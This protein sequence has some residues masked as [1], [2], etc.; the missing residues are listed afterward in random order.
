[1]DWQAS[2]AALADKLGA[3]GELRDPAWREAFEH[4]PRHV[5]VSGFDLREAYADEALVTQRRRAK[6]P[7]GDGID[8]PT[9]SASAPGVVAVMLDRLAVA[10]GMRVLEIGTGTGYNAALL[11][12]RLG[13]SNVYSIDLDPGLM[14]EAGTA[15]DAAG[16][17]PPLRAG[18]GYAG[19]PNAAP[20][21]RIIATC[22][23]N[24]IPPAWIDQLAQ[25]GRIVA[26][27]LGDECALMVLDKT[28][29]DEVTGRFDPYQVS[30][31]PLRDKI[32]N[33][34]AP[35]R[36]L[37]QV[38]STIGQYGTTDL[39]PSILDNTDRDLIMLL[40]LHLPGLSIGSV[41]GPDWQSLTLNTPQATAQVARA[42]IDGR[43]ATIQ[44]RQR[45][46]DTAEHVLRLWDLLGKPH[47]GRYGIS[48]INDRERQYVWLD[49]PD[50]DYAWPMPL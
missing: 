41:E 46:W 39:N 32:E 44:H 21:D 17:R 8:L 12:H 26:P 15:L 9:S 33:P 34:L 47:R 24:H 14:T 36:S 37:G 18:D 27:L 4:V 20:F 23:V 45:L 38:A 13:A 48:A 43:W 7:G 6:V 16:F 5:F 50:G 49:T 40:H 3:A 35:G 10:N 31:M 1:V 22:A 2:A 11:C 42:A 28:A 30:F 29:D 25:G 19:W